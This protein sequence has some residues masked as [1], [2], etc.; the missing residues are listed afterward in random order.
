MADDMT[1]VAQRRSDSSSPERKNL[2]ASVDEA[3]HN[4]WGRFCFGKADQHTQTGDRAHRPQRHT[5]DISCQ[6]AC[7]VRTIRSQS[8]HAVDVRIA[9]QVFE[10]T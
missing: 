9:H 6:L 4:L 2:D 7:T 10:L 3:P 8:A 1:A 5:P